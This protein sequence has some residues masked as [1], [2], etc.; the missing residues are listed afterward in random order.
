MSIRFYEPSMGIL[1]RPYGYPTT[2]ARIYDHFLAKMKIAR[3]PH[4]HRAVPVR[5]SYDVTAM[6]LRAYD[7]FKR[8]LASV[9]THGFS[10]N[11]A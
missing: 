11:F 3:C 4:D 6:C 7:F 1:R 8:G 5:G 10:L 2:S 9:P